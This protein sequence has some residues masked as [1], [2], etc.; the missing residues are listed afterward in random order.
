MKTATG[1]T[2]LAIGAILTF[3]VTANLWF[4]NIHIAGVV[5]MLAGLAG[6]FI[7]RRTYSSLN[8]RL[9]QRRTR[10]WPNGRV[11]E[12]NETSLPPYVVTASPSTEQAG[13]PGVPNIPPDPSPQSVMTGEPGSNRASGGPSLPPDPTV[14]AVMTPGGG[15]GAG[16]PASEDETIEQL[17]DD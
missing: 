13:L 14:R 17:R 4:F 2:L 12:T 6:L 5:I 7:P 3:A 11:V 9:V 15:S 8:R 10:T 1:I 16:G